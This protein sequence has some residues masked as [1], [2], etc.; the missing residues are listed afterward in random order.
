MLKLKKIYYLSMFC[1]LLWII[2][3]FSFSA[4]PV[5]ESVGLSRKVGQKVSE[6]FVPGFKELPQ[7]EQ[8]EFVQKI[9]FG[10]RKTAHFLEYMVLG[11]WWGFLLMPARRS[12]RFKIWTAVWASAACA[13]VDEIHQLFVDGRTGRWQDV[14]IDTAG[15][16]VGILALFAIIQLIHRRKVKTCQKHLQ[17]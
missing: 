7:G 3:I 11:I 9:D 13:A 12:V 2:V 16:A 17:S 5:T 1:L 4:Q 6:L 14:C 8:E 10:I 15:A